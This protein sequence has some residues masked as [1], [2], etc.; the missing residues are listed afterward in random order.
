MILPFLL[1]FSWLPAQQPP[2]QGAPFLAAPPSRSVDPP[3]LQI[4]PPGR[5]D[6]GSVGPK[7]PKERLYSFR[8]VSARP[9]ALRVLDLSPGV[10][11]QG[12]ALQGPIAPDGSAELTLRVDPTGFTGWQTRNVKLGTDDPKQGEYFLPVGLTVRADVTVDSLKKSF[13]EVALHETPQIA[14]HFRSETAAGTKLWVSSPLPAYLEAEVEAIPFAPGPEVLVV[15]PP[16]DLRGTKGAVRLTF[17]PALVE[18]G[19]HTG[20]ESV[21]VETSS[22]FEPKF[23]LYLNWR[24]RLPVKLSSPRVVFLDSKENEKTLTILPPESGKKFVVRGLRMEGT[25]FQI[26][27]VAPGPRSELR[28]RIKRTASAPAKAMLVLDLEGEILPL[29]VPLAY[30]PPVKGAPQKLRLDP[31]APAPNTHRHAH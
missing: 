21:T 25:G 12:P 7:E 13:G 5:A 31:P 8:N 16:P 28:L 11:V 17:R 22:P 14:F 3:R 24:L 6:L 1:S 19:V 9:I 18:A 10:T 2:A 30:L 23:Q 26:P 27:R 4:D 20:L 29:R 15:E